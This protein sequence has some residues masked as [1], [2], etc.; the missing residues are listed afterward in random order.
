[1]GDRANPFAPGPGLEPPHLAGRENELRAF[2][3]MLRNVARGRADNM[4]LHGLRGVGKTALLRRFAGACRGK[5]FLPVARRECGPRDSDPGEFAAG[6]EHAVRG[7][8]E[9]S[10]G[11]GA[12]NG[13]PS[14][15]GRRLGPAPAGARGPARCEPPCART[16][17]APLGDHMADYLAKSWKVV[18]GLGYDGA[19]FLLDDFHAVGGSKKG[20]RRALADFLGAVN[21]AQK[22]GCRYSLVLSG[23]PPVL[24]HVRAAR[25][26]AERMF[27]TVEVPCLSPPGGR[28][29]VTRPL[30]GAGAA[31]S[32]ALVD[33]VVEDS[34]G[35]PYFVQFIAREVLRRTG[36][37]RVG[38]REYK[39]IRDGVAG[40]MRSEFFG[41]RM[42]GASAGEMDTLRHMSRMP[43]DAMRFSPIVSATGRGKGAVSSD[44]ERLEKKGMVY[45]RS[46]GLYAFALPML[47]SYL[48]RAGAQGAAAP[49][50]P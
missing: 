40:K 21:E 8:I 3:D 12:A 2:D 24:Q 26:Y 50:R 29:A 35:C 47:G 13:E 38:M 36:A 45:R 6:I 16:G 42:A 18:D 17:R 19:V 41:R 27:G 37:Q 39:R 23:L 28:E 30:A 32:P 48:S 15:A 11:A 46:R 33:A 22:D 4:V 25:S 10:P 7:A 34:G 5:R 9:S 20:G 14:P 44:L 43:E 1:M 49:C 31:F